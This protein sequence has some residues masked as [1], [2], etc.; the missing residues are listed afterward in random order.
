LLRFA[1]PHAR[2]YCNLSCRTSYAL[3]HALHR[4]FAVSVPIQASRRRL[5]IDRFTCPGSARSAR[6]D[7]RRRTLLLLASFDASLKQ[8]RAE[9]LEATCSSVIAV[10]QPQ[11]MGRPD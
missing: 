6:P 10:T 1:P 7:V 9:L 3:Y 4:R 2:L 11:L 5:S 8:A